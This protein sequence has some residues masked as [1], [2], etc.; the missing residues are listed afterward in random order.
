M[1]HFGGRQVVVLDAKYATVAN[2][3]TA[4]TEAL[5]SLGNKAS[6]TDVVFD[7][8]T[9]VAAAFRFQNALKEVV[10]RDFVPIQTL[11]QSTS[12]VTYGI[13]HW[14]LDDGSGTVNHH[15]YVGI[16]RDD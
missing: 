12:T 13:N 8:G 4:L 10:G 3:R 1:V 9:D 5:R 2:A 7:F 14:S 16:Q 11:R 15:V 6:R